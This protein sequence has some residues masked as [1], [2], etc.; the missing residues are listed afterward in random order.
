MKSLAKP[1]HPA[2]RRRHA[3]PELP[4]VRPRAGYRFQGLLLVPLPPADQEYIAPGG[5][6][7]Y[8]GIADPE[9]ARDR[10]HLQC[11]GKHRAAEPQLL[12]K[13]TP[14]DLIRQGGG[15][16]A[17][18]RGVE[19]VTGHE[20]GNPRT[21]GETER[22]KVSLAERVPG[23]SHDGKLH[24]GIG[25]GIAVPREVFP[26]GKNAAS[27]NPAQKGDPQ[28]RDGMRVRGNGPVSNHGVDRV[29]VD[30]E[31]GGEVD[32]DPD[33][34]QFLSDRP[35]DGLRHARSPAAEKGVAPGRGKAGKSRCREAH[36]PATFLV[37]GDERG[38]TS[39]PGGG[40][41]LPAQIPD[42]AGGLHV[43][44]EQDHAGHGSFPEPS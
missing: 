39:P 37:D 25:C 2:S 26:D 8:G 14:E 35:A 32:V 18:Q 12:A 19:Y 34:A 13:E 6:G 24:V 21:N 5:N 16:L 9:P 42:L 17:I 28:L 36:Y 22:V 43:S 38:G 31:D 30:V 11:I 7:P 41:D 15:E 4:V 23:A 27:Q 1:E 29:A 3:F 40:A 44:R 33:G 20:R 10:F